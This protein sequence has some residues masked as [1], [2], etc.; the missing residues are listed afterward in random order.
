MTWCRRSMSRSI[1][2]PFFFISCLY[3]LSL[4]F[5]T[6]CIRRNCNNNTS[7]THTNTSAHN[8]SFFLR[9]VNF[10]NNINTSEACALYVSTSHNDITPCVPYSLLSVLMECFLILLSHN[11]HCY[12]WDSSSFNLLFVCVLQLLT[13][14]QLLVSHFFI[15]WYCL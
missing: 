5:T 13:Y 14:I 15:Y 12:V 10:S 4:S 6:D 8:C 1:S 11:F 7:V 2:L 9:T 3:W